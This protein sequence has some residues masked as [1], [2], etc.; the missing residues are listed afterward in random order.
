MT[1][2]SMF[3]AT[4]SRASSPSAR[5]V[6]AASAPAR[7]TFIAEDPAMP[8]PTGESD[9]VRTSTARAPK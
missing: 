5:P 4:V 2:A 6:Q 8:A 1:C 9:R 3:I 7:A